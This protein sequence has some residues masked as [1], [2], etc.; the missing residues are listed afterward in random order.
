MRIANL[1]RAGRKCVVL[2]RTYAILAL[3]QSKGFT[4]FEHADGD[5]H[6]PC[7]SSAMRSSG[8]TVHV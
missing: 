6:S 1:L 7:A 5:T 8:A 3:I 2:L 4:G